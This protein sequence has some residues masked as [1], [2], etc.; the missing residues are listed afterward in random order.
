M[1]LPF[2]YESIVIREH[3]DIQ[4]LLKLI[5]HRPNLVPYIRALVYS[6]KMESIKDRKKQ[7][8]YPTMLNL[9]RGLPQLE[10]VTWGTN[11]IPSEA[12]WNMLL[13]KCGSYFFHCTMLSHKN[14]SHRLRELRINLNIENEASKAFLTTSK[15]S[16]QS[17][18]FSHS[19]PPD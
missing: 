19:S 5:A 18:Q 1:I 15:A 3:Q 6:L 10:S 7:K 14:R 8:S 4:A 11:D 12:I 13:I 16:Q 9:V 2:I 17:I